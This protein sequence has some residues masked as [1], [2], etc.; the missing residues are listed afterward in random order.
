MNKKKK[1]YI[2][3]TAGLP[4]TYGGWE[5]LADN[6]VGNLEKS[7]SFVV[8][9]S[10]PNY[11]NQLS[12]YKNAELRYSRFRANG[13]QSLLYDAVTMLDATRDKNATLLILGI[14]G[15]FLLPLLIIK[16]FLTKSNNVFI[17]NI[18][19]IEWKRQKWGLIE[20]LILKINEWFAVRFS[21]Y[22]ISDNKGISEYV[23]EKYKVTSYMIPYGGDQVNN[24]LLEKD[25][26]ATLESYEIN[27][28]FYLTV[29]RIEPENNL[30]IFIDA[31]RLMPEKQFI[32]I[33]N[34]NSS[35][36]GKNLYIRCKKIKNIKML[37]GIYDQ[38][39]LDAI[40]KS[41][42]VYFHGHSA[43]GTNP[44]LVEAMHLSLNVVCYDVNFNRYTTS[45]FAKYIS[46]PESLIKIIEGLDSQKIDPWGTDLELFA[47]EFYKWKNIS[48]DYVKVFDNETT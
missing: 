34:Y 6:L 32:I 12:S 39:K 30:E 40:R 37:G 25:V 21:D 18:D 5:T 48:D 7:Y 14:S 10:A 1:I 27:S 9:C 45:G 43:G 26:E 13:A 46:N 38:A 28:K 20:R 16:R 22:V 8:Y 23:Y 41:S 36:Y 24:N 4:N 3:G 2:I 15:A 33:G 31:A 35:E 29:S 47:K 17:T 44:A 11:K 42:E 19:G